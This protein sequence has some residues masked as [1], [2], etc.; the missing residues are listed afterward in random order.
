MFRASFPP[1]SDGQVAGGGSGG[2]AAGF[3]GYPSGWLVD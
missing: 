1:P 3:A 2:A